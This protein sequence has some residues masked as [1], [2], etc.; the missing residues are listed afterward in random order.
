MSIPITTKTISINCFIHSVNHF[1]YSGSISFVSKIDIF[2]P[3]G[4]LISL[5]S[6]RCSP[7][8]VD[9][10]SFVGYGLSFAATSTRK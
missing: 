1:D 8:A 5:Q 9:H 10:Y 2:Y 4:E 7:L 6:L 3:L